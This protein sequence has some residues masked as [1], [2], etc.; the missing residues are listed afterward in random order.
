ME[1]S[2]MKKKWS[3]V[4]LH[5]LAGLFTCIISYKLYESYEERVFV[6]K[7]SPLVQMPIV[8]RVKGLGTVRSP[9]K[10]WVW[11]KGRRYTLETSNPYFRKTAKDE[12]IEVNFDPVRDI[13]VRPDENP[14]HFYP[15]LVII[16]LTGLLLLGYAIY[17]FRSTIISQKEG[18]E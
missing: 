16:F 6:Q 15:L 1:L 17:D 5:A 2:S 14:R 3:R 7:H 11:Y 18:L 8:G 10:I 9:N 4:L 13:A 12:S